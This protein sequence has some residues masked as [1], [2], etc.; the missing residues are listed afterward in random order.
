MTREEKKKWL[1]RYRYS[2]FKRDSLAAQANEL[3][4]RVISIPCKRIDGMPFNPSSDKSGD[5]QYVKYLVLQ[6]EADNALIEAVQIR[7]E[8]ETCISQLE[9]LNLIQVLTYRYLEG[10]NWKEIKS[11][12]GFGHAWV[13]RLHNEALDTLYIEITDDSRKE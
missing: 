1:S 8:I 13:Y 9:D 3:Y 4:E 10:L 6:E 12:M 5:T 11:K 7:R 2:L